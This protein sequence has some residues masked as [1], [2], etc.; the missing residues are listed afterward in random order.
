MNTLATVLAVL[1]SVRLMVYAFGTLEI[2]LLGLIGFGFAA[3][4]LVMV[5]AALGDDDEVLSR[6]IKKRRG[7]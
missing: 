3:F 5:P 2:E 1:A 7:E 4:W 6:W